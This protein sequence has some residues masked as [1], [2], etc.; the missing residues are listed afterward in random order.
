MSYPL[1]MTNI[2]MEAMAHRN[3][4][5]SELKNGGSFQ[6][7]ML[8]ITRWYILSTPFIVGLPIKNGDFPWLCL[9]QDIFF[10]VSE[11]SV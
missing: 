3:S 1:V 9:L 5:F 10:F 4:W 6:F 7:A 11:V 2:A 8:V